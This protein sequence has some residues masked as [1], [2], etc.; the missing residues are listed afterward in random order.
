MADTFT[1]NLTLTKPE[2]GTSE[3]VWGNKTNLNWDAVDAEFNPTGTTALVRRSMLVG[4]TSESAGVPTGAAFQTA[5]NANGRFLRLADGTQ[6]CWHTI[7]T[8]TGASSTWTFPA[9]FSGSDR[10]VTTTVRGT[11]VAVGWTESLSNT[12]VGVSAFDLT[13]SRV[14]RSVDLVAVGR[15]F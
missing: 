9:A 12:S 15:W 1:T 4:T 11:A 6:I 8:G 3:N 5:S 10:V 7:A 2:I 13:G 14:V